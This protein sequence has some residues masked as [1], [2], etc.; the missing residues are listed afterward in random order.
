MPTEQP[1]DHRAL[2]V[3]HG[4]SWIKPQDEVEIPERGLVGAFF[5]MSRAARHKRSTRLSS[6]RNTTSRSPMAASGSRLMV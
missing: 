5:A 2:M 4:G 3:D 1:I 6:R